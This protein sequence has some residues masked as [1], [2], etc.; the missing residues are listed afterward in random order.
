[1]AIAIG[2]VYF[3]MSDS[4]YLQPILGATKKNP[5]FSVYQHNE[6]GLFHVFYGLSV[7]DVVPNDKKDARFRLMVVH[8]RTIGLSQKALARAFDLDPRTV[9]AWSDALHSGNG[10]RIERVLLNPGS[11]RK[12]SKTI[13]QFIRV[14]FKYLYRKEKYRYSSVIR[15]EI[16]EIYDVELSAETLRPLF[17]ELKA[18]FL[19]E[20][21]KGPTDHEDSDNNTGSEEQQEQ[22]MVLNTP[23]AESDRPNHSSMENKGVDDPTNTSSTFE[24]SPPDILKHSESLKNNRKPSAPFSGWCSHLGLVFFNEALA[25]LKNRLAESAFGNNAVQWIQQVLLG[26]GNL[27]QTKLLDINDLQSLFGAPVMGSPGNQRSK[28]SEIID[29]GCGLGSQLLR[30][31]FSR[32]DDPEQRDFYFDP[33]T[34]QYT[35]KKNILKGWCSKTR[36]AERIQNGDYAHTRKGEPVYLENTD[37]YNDMRQ[38]FMSFE[39]NFR[40][41]LEI[42][43][44]TELTWIIDRGIYSQ[45][46]FGWILNSPN[47]HLITWERDYRADGWAC[48]ARAHAEMIKQRPRNH[49]NDLRNYHFEWIEHPWPK[50]PE[51]RRLIVRATHPEGKKIE[52]SILCDDWQR[53]AQSIIW[54]MFDRWV[55]ENDFKYLSAHFG[56]DEITSYASESYRDIYA[57]LEDRT[58]KNSAY[59]AIEK[60]RQQERKDLGKLLVQQRRAKKTQLKRLEEI[61]Q[62]SRIRTRTPQQKKRLGSLKGADRS[63]QK[64]IDHREQKIANCE[65]QIELHDRELANTLKE[66]SRLET[67]VAG[68]AVRLDSRKKQLMDII[69]ITAR[70]IFYHCFAP[71]RQAYNNYRDDHVWF[72]HLTQRT[73]GIIRTEEQINCELVLTGSYTKPVKAAIDT[74]LADYNRQAPKY[75][76]G[77][78]LTTTLKILPKT[79]IKSAI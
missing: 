62:L 21:S 48:S 4:N 28:L 13:E 36:W 54:A 38:R 33:H 59:A 44:E 77:C 8:L 65:A 72:R 31:N 25:S 51:L 68:R 15:S 73:G 24:K 39:S 16:K 7:F 35:G 19:K 26:A 41:T 58:V 40:T 3:S 50:Q 10:D 64:H 66:V 67:L 49:R 55:Q 53:S 18:E 78:D 30:W 69:K 22:A 29:S 17:Q 56:I 47:K 52:V 42:A 74:I 6:T 60:S 32:V 23:P 75:F 61:K 70:N 57:E 20:Q 5:I 2:L 9:K 37:S 71:F 14:R 27:E 46:I 79:A 76:N 43:E 11:N 12:V 63:A 34:T 1:M 45:D